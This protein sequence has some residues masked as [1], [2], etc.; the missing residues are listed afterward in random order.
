MHD[1]NGTYLYCDGTKYK[2][3]FFHN[4]MT[5]NCEI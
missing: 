3:S 4:S 1:K 5:G 2:G